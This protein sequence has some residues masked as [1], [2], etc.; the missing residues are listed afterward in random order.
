MSFLSALLLGLL[1]S[2][3]CAGMCGG[4]QAALAHSPVLRSP[5]QN[6]LH[7]LTMNAG[8]ISCYILAGMVLAWFGSEVGELLNIPEW[9][10]WLRMFA[11]GVILLIGFQLLFTNNKPLGWL[12]NKAYRLWQHIKPA[13]NR[14]N[15]IHY[16]HSFKRGLLW[17][18]LP[19]GLVYSILLAASV[20]GSAT[21]GL[22]VMLGFGLGT[23][24]AM[25]LTGNA[26]IGF[27]GF[28][29]HKQV[30]QAGGVFFILIGV[31]ILIAP[32]LITHDHIA[33]HPLFY[34]LAR[35]VL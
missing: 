1:T 11:A 7:L 13:L 3:H 4:V 8:R 20:S 2:L 22:L 17:G 27:R 10:Y 32:L 30:Q 25:L 26:F 14:Q 18:L 9:T 28:L 23:L 31:A 19:C 24:P 33:S 5:M 15:G 29:Q 34:N 16:H 21:N 35:C 12:E 6:Q